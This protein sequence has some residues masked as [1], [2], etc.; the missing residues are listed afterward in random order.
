VVQADAGRLPFADGSF[1]AA[2]SSYGALPFVADVTAVLTEVARVLRPGARFVFSVA[3]PFRWCFLDE[4]GDEGMFACHPYF[5]RRAY[6]ESDDHEVAVYVEHHR[7]MGDW[8]RAIRT[9][10]LRLADVVEPAWPEDNDQ[11]WGGWS[12]RRG[13]IIPGTAIFVTDKPD[14]AE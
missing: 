1:D 11:T 14:R 4:P 12:P 9:A 5:D 6:V 2:C 3:H 10:G 13:R 8:I 7:T